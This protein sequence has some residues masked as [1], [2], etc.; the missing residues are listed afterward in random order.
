MLLGKIND[1][2]GSSRPIYLEIENF[3]IIKQTT[4]I[5]DKSWIKK[6]PRWL[7]LWIYG[8][9][10]EPLVG[11][12]VNYFYMRIF[13]QI[14]PFWQSSSING[15]FWYLGNTIRAEDEFIFAIIAQIV[16]LTPLV[17]TVGCEI[18]KKIYIYW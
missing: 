12:R 15:V 6:T 7:S 18:T 4:Y 2:N 10:W 16:V 9:L 3:Q 5:A 14:Y 11:I 1:C 13:I 8:V 17:K